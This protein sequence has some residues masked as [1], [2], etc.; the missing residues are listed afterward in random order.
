MN[1]VEVKN[2][3]VLV[4]NR[5]ILRD[6]SLQIDQLQHT[7]IIGPNGSGK[8]TFI[9]LL[10]KEIYPSFVNGIAS[11]VKVLGRDDWNIFEMR[12]LISLVS[13]KFGEHLLSA[14]PLDLFDAVTSSFFGTYGFFSDEKVSTDQKKEV[15]QVLEK[16]DLTKL[17]GSSIENFSTGELRKTLIARAAVLRPQLLL[18][19]EPTNGLDV[20]AQSEFLNYL[21]KIAAETTILMVTHHLEEIILAVK[22]VLL[23]KDGR[24]F[25]FGVKEEILTSKNL[26]ELFGVALEVSKS[27]SGIYSMRRI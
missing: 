27:V 3:N 17:Q 26:S 20:A 10:M 11:Q 9:R 15:E 23:I 19:D 8:S 24:V 14:T 7:A 1:I 16:L 4:E 6:F 21:E 2:C 13:P 22:N 12:K 18:L 5:A 25:A